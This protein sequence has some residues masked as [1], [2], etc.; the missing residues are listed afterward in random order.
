MSG[1]FQRLAQRSGLLAAAT[2][3]P[4]PSPLEVDTVRAVVAPATV[5]SDDDVLPS[6]W[7][8]NPPRSAMP[9]NGSAELPAPIAPRANPAPID[10]PMIQRKTDPA[11]PEASQ[12]PPSA[13]RGLQESNSTE[14]AAPAAQAQPTVQM[15][16]PKADAVPP[17]MP[18]TAYS[19]SSSGADPEL[20]EPPMATFHT[21]EVQVD[22][23]QMSSRADAKAPVAGAALNSAHVDQ[24]ASPFSSAQATPASSAARLP[25]MAPPV[26]APVQQRPAIAM[27]APASRPAPGRRS[28]ET[29]SVRIG[30]V[31][32]D[33]HAPPP[34]PAPVY[35]SPR[36]AAPATPPPGPALRRFYLRSW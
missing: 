28:A 10:A 1:Y 4:A 18:S 11:P 26:A 6:V 7:P 12:R 9:A 20:V 14:V 24:A 19:H 36:S 30:Q 33:V 32:V 16:V 13:A 17:A 22:Q 35:V 15:H 34:A 23:R 27:P 3:T 31:Q 5:A 29:P 21:V 25:A 2:P 8:P